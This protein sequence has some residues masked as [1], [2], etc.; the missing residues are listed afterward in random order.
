M[1]SKWQLSPQLFASVALYR[2][3]EKDMSLS[4]NGTT[5]AINKARSTGAEFEL[6]GEILPD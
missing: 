6:N 3:D 1:G 4:I 5:R 2:I